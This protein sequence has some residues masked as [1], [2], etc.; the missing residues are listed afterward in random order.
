MIY[1]RFCVSLLS[2]NNSENIKYICSLPSALCFPAVPQSCQSALPETSSSSVAAW[3]YLSFLYNKES[4][5]KAISL[6]KSSIESPTDSL[7]S[8]NN[9]LVLYIYTESLKTIRAL[10]WKKSNCHKNSIFVGRYR[11]K[12]LYVTCTVYV[13]TG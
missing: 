12:K 9:L 7:I 13:S 1:I 4:T 11:P 10:L 3:P 5:A 6:P 8:F 2:T